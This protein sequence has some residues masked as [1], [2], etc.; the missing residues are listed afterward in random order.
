LDSFSREG[1]KSRRRGKR[2]KEYHRKGGGNAEVKESWRKNFGRVEDWRKGTEKPHLMGQL[3][4]FHRRSGTVRFQ[5]KYPE[6]K[7]L[8]VWEFGE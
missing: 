3:L 4:R 1:E 6:T 7:R 8:D 5:T 2:R